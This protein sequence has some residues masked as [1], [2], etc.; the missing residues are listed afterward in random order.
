MR[1]QSFN[2]APEFPQN[3]NLQQKCIKIFQ[4]EDFVTIF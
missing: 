1:A 4:Q 3:G 2:F